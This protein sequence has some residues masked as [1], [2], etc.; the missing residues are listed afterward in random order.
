MF[1]TRNKNICLYEQLANIIQILLKFIFK[2][3]GSYNLIL[4]LSGQDIFSRETRLK[5]HQFIH[6]I[7]ELWICLA[8][9]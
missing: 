2:T 7:R 8:L 1:I 5:S 9:L 3:G 4:H 6:N